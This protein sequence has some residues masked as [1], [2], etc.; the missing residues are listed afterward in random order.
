MVARVRLLAGE[1]AL[2]CYRFDKGDV[3]AR[4][5]ELVPSYLSRVPQDPFT[6]RGLYYRPQGTNWLLLSAGLAGVDTQ[7]EPH[8]QEFS[9]RNGPFLGGEW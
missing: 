5:E 2:R 3:P 8:N 7:G 6:G 4:L 9:A 1:M